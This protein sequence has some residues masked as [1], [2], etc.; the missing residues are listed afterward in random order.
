MDN[1]GLQLICLGQLMYTEITSTHLTDLL[2]SSGLDELREELRDGNVGFL[3]VE[4]TSS[5]GTSQQR[6]H[7]DAV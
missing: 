3:V 2:V 6:L 5:H 7:T 4:S 1:T